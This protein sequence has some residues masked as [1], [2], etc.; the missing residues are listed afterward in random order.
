MYP[1]KTVQ[2]KSILPSLL[3]KPFC[4]TQ[5]CRQKKAEVMTTAEYQFRCMKHKIA[6]LSNTVHKIGMAIRPTFQTGQA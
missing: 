4:H 3:M 6:A 1:L 2:V 5:D